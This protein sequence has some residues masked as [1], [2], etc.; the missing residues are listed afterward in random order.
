MPLRGRDASPFCIKIILFVGVGVLDDPF[1]HKRQSSDCRTGRPGGRP[2]QYQ[3]GGRAFARPPCFMRLY[4]G[5]LP[6]FLQ[7]GGHF[8]A[9]GAQQQALDVDAHAGG[10]ALG[11]LGGGVDDVA[12]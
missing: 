2:L 3:N 11:D 10:D 9:Q 5:I 7:V 6:D 8:A 12:H 4:L 1:P